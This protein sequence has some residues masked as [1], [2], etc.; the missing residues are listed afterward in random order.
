M[1]EQDFGLELSVPHSRYRFE[2]AE[3]KAALNDLNYLSLETTQFKE[4]ALLISNKVIR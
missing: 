1:H 2:S 4:L 3:N